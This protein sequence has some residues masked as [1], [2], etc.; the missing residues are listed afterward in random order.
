MALNVKV[1]L[2]R[3]IEANL[4]TLASTGQAGVLALATDTNA[5]YIDQGS[6]TAGIGN[7]G[8]GKAWIRSAAGTQVFSVATQAAMLLLSGASTGDIA[9]RSDLN[10]V[11]MLTGFTTSAYSTLGN[12]TQVGVIGTAITGL[13]S[14]TT[15]QWVTYVDTTGVQHLAQPAFSDISSALAQTQLPASIGATSSLTSFDCGTF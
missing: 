14:G 3:G 12:W 10:Q 7:P 1:A 2:Y 11:F 8:S 15:H 5:L 4:A 13:A 6:G 9:V